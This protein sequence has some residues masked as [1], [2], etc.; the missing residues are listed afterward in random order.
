MNDTQ[1]LKI[2]SALLQK[3]QSTLFPSAGQVFRRLF[4][5]HLISSLLTLS[6]CPQF[7]FRLVGEGHG[8]MHYFMFAG[9]YGCQ[10][11]CGAFYMLS[12]VLL[13]LFVLNTY[14]VRTLTRS[15]LVFIPALSLL[16]LATFNVMSPDESLLINLAWLSG[17]IGMSLPVLFLR[18]F[19]SHLGAKT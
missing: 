13:S 6:I 11:L 16:S 9:T 15:S 10:V 14:Q 18:R 7:G 3:A 19:L 4:A 2:K 17:A 12:T 5:L 8:L 1:F